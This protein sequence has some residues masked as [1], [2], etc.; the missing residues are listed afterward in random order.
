MPALGKKSKQHTI[1][2]MLVINDWLDE[3]GICLF[4]K[5]K[6]WFIGPNGYLSI[7]GG[8]LHRMIMGNIPKGMTIDHKNDN[9]LDNRLENLHIVCQGYNSAN[10]PNQ[11][12]TTEKYKCIYEQPNG[13]FVVITCKKC[14]GTYDNLKDARAAYL[15]Y[16]KDKFGR[17]LTNVG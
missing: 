6:G 11:K 17:E 7:K 13:K 15:G 1:L 9:K 3:T 14:L 8:Y 5:Y 12:N 10:R 16:I 2:P 4:K